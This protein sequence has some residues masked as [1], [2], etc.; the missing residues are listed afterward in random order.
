MALA[1]GLLTLLA[2][3]WIVLILSVS[4]ALATHAARHPLFPVLLAS[5]VVFVLAHFLTY[6]SYYGAGVR[7]IEREP[8]SPAWIFILVVLAA[9]S[10][11]AARMVEPRLGMLV[12]A[13]TL[14]ICM[15]SAF[16]VQAGH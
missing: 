11:V 15:V 7:Y 13:C 4:Q 9:A 2:A 1:I 14:F 6:D 5:A 12:S 3:S 10:V 8:T 16:F